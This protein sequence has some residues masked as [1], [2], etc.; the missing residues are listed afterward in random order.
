[1]S[2]R[3]EL[4]TINKKL[5]EKELKRK[6]QRVRDTVD[7]ALNDWG[8]KTVGKF[9]M[10][11]LMGRPGLVKRRGTLSQN[12]RFRTF[13][14]GM[15]AEGHF[16]IGGPA[17]KYAAIHEYGGTIFPKKGKYLTFPILAPTGTKIIGWRKATSVTIPPRLKFKDTIKELFPELKKQMAKTIQRGLD[18]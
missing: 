15:E 17:G 14:S 7:D 10:K 5:L 12:T 6:N 1:M 16:T 13:G 2:R 4:I 9:K 3:D 8:L 11:Q 18:G